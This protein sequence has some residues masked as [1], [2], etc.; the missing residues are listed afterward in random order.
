MVRTKTYSADQEAIAEEFNDV[1]PFMNKAT[2][3]ENAKTEDCSGKDEEDD[4]AHELAFKSRFVSDLSGGH[5]SNL[6]NDSSG[7]S[8]NNHSYTFAVNTQTAVECNIAGFKD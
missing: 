2:S 8:A 6:A 7:A 4:V 5:V 3:N 1:S